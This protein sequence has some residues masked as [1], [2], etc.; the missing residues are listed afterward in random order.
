MRHCPTRGSPAR[1]KTWRAMLPQVAAQFQSLETTMLTEMA[2]TLSAGGI[3]D[4][5]ADIVTRELEALRIDTPE[6]GLAP[7][8]DLT[9]RIALSP[10]TRH[11]CGGHCP[12]RCRCRGSQ[13]S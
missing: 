2:A 11:Q 12:D 9:G 5:V 10:A 1:L 8:T 4:R 6:T 13:G 7:G 3:P